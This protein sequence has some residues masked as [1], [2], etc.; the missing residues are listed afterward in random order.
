MRIDIWF[1]TLLGALI[2]QGS[3]DASAWK[4]RVHLKW[5]LQ[6]T[7]PSMFCRKRGR[8]IFKMDVGLFV[9]LGA[10]QRYACL[11][12]EVPDGSSCRSPERVLLISR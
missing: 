2:V 3:N 7:C 1:L 11:E 9:Y 6:L 4:E 10:H 8:P 5:L 12:E